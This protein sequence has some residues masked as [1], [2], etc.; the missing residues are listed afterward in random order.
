MLKNIIK[1]AIQR[2]AYEFLNPPIKNLGYKGIYKT[3]SEVKKWFNTS[4]DIKKDFQTSASIMEKGGTGCYPA[5]NFN[6]PRLNR[7]TG[8]HFNARNYR[9]SK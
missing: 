8:I 5:P 4:K 3:S 2:N 1:Q 9:F 7:C 6:K